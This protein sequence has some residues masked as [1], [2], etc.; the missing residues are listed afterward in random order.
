MQSTSS[1][2]K[3]T[4]GLKKIAKYEKKNIYLYYVWNSSNKKLRQNA[5]RVN[6]F[7]FETK[8]KTKTNYETKTNKQ[9]WK[10]TRKPRKKTN[11]LIKLY[12]IINL[13]Q[14]SIIFNV[15]KKIRRYKQQTTTTTKKR[16][17]NIEN[18]FKERMKK[19]KEKV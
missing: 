14:D 8:I 7:F 17:R 16:E 12:Y 13:L 18:K 15:K 10:L 5:R 4:N 6:F 19:K 1:R 3:F 11:D 9:K 2:S